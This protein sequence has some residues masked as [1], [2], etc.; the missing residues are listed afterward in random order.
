LAKSTGHVLIDG[1]LVHKY[2]NSSGAMWL[3]EDMN[4][5]PKAREL[6][7]ACYGLKSGHGVIIKYRTVNTLKSRSK[8]R[9]DQWG[10]LYDVDGDFVDFLTTKSIKRVPFS[11]GDFQV[12]KNFRTVPMNEIYHSKTQTKAFEFLLDDMKV[13]EKFEKSKR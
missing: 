1:V 12:P 5:S 2:E 3:A 8:T 9:A 6:L 7:I 10:T 11:S 13:G 4:I